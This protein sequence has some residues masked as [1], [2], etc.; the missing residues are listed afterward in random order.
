[1]KRFTQLLT[2]LVFLSLIIFMSCKK[3]N[4]GGGTDPEPEPDP[5][6]DFGAALN[7]TTW[8]PSGV[9]LKEE[10]RTEWADAGFTLTLN[11]VTDSNQGNYS[12][13]NLPEIDGSDAVWGANVSWSI[14]SVDDSG[15]IATIDRSDLTG[16]MTATLNSITAPTQLILTFNIPEPSARVAGFNGDWEFTFTKQ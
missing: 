14:T 3:E 6:A 15:L 1:M 12:I 8:T 9:T 13:T 10:D 4:G 5:V 2:A 11:Y 7:A 16:N